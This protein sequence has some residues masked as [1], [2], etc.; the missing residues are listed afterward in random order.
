ILCRSGYSTLMDLRACGKK[1][2]IV[3]TPGQKE[4]EYL[5][6]KNNGRFG[7][8]SAVQ[9]GEKL[10]VHLKEIENLPEP[11]AAKSNIGNFIEDWLTNF[12][13]SLQVK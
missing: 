7:F 2:L 12:S 1:A 8:I 13:Q 6:E 9:S 5:A 3:P 4:Q 11:L 10:K